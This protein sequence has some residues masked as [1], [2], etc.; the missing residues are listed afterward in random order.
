M[1]CVVHDTHHYIPSRTSRGPAR[2]RSETSEFMMPASAAE[3]NTRD[4]RLAGGASREMWERRVTVDP[5]GAAT[6]VSTM[7]LTR[8]T[9]STSESVA[10]SE[11]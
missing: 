4:G 8:T 5:L 2:P 3:W 11:T 10:E 7:T 6:A 1:Q 9:D